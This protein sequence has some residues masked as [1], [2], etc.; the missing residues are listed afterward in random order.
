[1]L[2]A[3]TC[4]AL[5]LMRGFS[6]RLCLSL[7]ITM[8]ASAMIAKVLRAGGRVRFRAY[9]GSMGEAIRRGDIV[10]VEPV[11]VAELRR[12]DIV[13][14]ERQGRLVVHRLLAILE[15]ADRGVRLIVRGDSHRSCD[16]PVPAH[17]L[18]GRVAA[19]SSGAVVGAKAAVG[20]LGRS[21]RPWARDWAPFAGRLGRGAG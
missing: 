18:L 3:P 21:L 9:G 2:S 17:A 6:I 7:L 13:V 4:P 8:V 14:Y 10:E 16:P 12:A 19:V 5:S 11:T 1:M 15:H 20:A